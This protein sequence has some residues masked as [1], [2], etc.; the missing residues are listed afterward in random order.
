MQRMSQ[1]GKEWH[2]Y[3]VFELCPRLFKKTDLC[4]LTD[5]TLTLVLVYTGLTTQDRHTMWKVNVNIWAHTRI[6][7]VK[8]KHH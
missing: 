1:V 8:W 4:D 2:T 6:V 7:S 5:L 3:K